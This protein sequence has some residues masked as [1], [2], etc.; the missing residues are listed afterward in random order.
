MALLEHGYVKL[1]QVIELV[2][3]MP[4]D[5]NRQRTLRASVRRW[6]KLLREAGHDIPDE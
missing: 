5:A 4:I 6:W 3:T 1:A 2:P